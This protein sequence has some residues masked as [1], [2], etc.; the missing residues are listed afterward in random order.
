MSDLATYQNWIG[1]GFS[2]LDENWGPDQS[3]ADVRDGF[4]SAI[5]VSESDL[6]TPE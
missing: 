5:G 3:W 1:L 4:L 2:H 6:A